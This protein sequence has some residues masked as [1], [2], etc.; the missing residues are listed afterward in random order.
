[1]SALYA[2]TVCSTVV[3]RRSITLRSNVDST[4]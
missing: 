1:M 3:R 2:T 4:A